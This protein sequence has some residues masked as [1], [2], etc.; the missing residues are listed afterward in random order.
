MTDNRREPTPP[1]DAGLS[2]EWIQQQFGVR[3]Q[4]C[5][6]HMTVSDGGGAERHVHMEWNDDTAIGDL[7]VID[8]GNGGFPTV[9]V[10]TVGQV[11]GLMKLYGVLEKS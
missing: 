3:K 10:S 2:L 9:Y 1:D 4:F 5:N 7:Y 11:R 6:I 8:G